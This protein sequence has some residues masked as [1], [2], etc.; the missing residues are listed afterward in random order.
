MKRRSDLSREKG[1]L[2][3]FMLGFSSLS[4]A[5]AHGQTGQWASL[6]HDFLVCLVGAFI[7]SG[8]VYKQCIRGRKHRGKKHGFHQQKRSHRVCCMG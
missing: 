3:L 2:F 4:F 1:I 8:V 7:V 5:L 6:L